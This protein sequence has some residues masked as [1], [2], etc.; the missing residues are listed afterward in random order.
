MNEC[1]FHS[2]GRILY[3]ISD[4]THIST[5]IITSRKRRQEKEAQE[6]HFRSDTMIYCTREPM[7]L[8]WSR[9]RG[10]SIKSFQRMNV[11]PKVHYAR[12]YQASYHSFY[13]FA[14][15]FISFHT[16]HEYRSESV[17]C[18]VR[19][20]VSVPCQKFLP[21]SR[22]KQNIIKKTTWCK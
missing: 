18:R 2:S 9:T 8:R 11:T 5:Y 14:A 3:P 6:W 12:T 1:H 10:P 15:Q 20:I 4:G 13:S 16:P 7:P 19:L 17:T 21:A 22:V